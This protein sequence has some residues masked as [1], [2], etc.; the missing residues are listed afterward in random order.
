MTTPTID[1]RRAALLARFPTWV[2]SALDELLA[3][4]A[5]AHPD[6][7]LVITGERSWS[8]RDL[9]DWA[10]RL[11]DG[12]VERGVSAGDHVAVVLANVPE[13]VPLKFAI[14]RAGA[15]CVPLN[16]RY[17]RDELTYVLAQSGAVAL[18][19]MDGFA[20]LDHLAV[21]DDIVAA[22]ATPGLRDVIVV[23]VI[24]SMPADRTTLAALEALGAGHPGA[25]SGRRRAPDAPGDILYTSG[26]TGS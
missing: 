11:A 18:V 15:V 22:G 3:Q 5:A 13:F 23:P 10:T 26:T 12:L 20:G 21:V 16:Y 19:T 2:P 25:S 4:A 14:A 9:D 24:G 7:P 17:R 8:Y 1:Q 6:R